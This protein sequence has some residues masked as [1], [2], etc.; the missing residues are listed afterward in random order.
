M[1]HSLITARGNSKGIK[2]KNL[3]KVGKKSLVKNIIDILKENKKISK[4]IFLSSDSNK[5]LEI[6]RKNK[7]NLIKRPKSISSGNS[8][9]EEAVFHYINYLKL[10][11]INLPDILLLI[12]PTSPFIKNKTINQVISVLQKNKKT[13][14]AVTLI[15]TNHKYHF[16][17]QR[18]LNKKN[19]IQFIFPKK[20]LEQYNR[21]N[22][23]D[24]YVHGNIFAFKITKF[25]H[26]KK[27]IA[28]PCQGI[29][30]DNELEAIDIDNPNDLKL[31]NFLHKYITASK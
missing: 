2:N 10:R 23:L 25:L 17:N 15:K 5:I 16:L 27:I 12:Q 31:A 7:I 21:Q 19:D 4:N 3:Q 1:I 6:G 29:I 11:K 14:S 24:T 9:S 13:S 26:Q 28:E 30:L 20:R 8:R 18:I 22:K